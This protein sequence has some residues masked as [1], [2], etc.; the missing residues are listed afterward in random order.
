M[1]THNNSS[2]QVIKGSHMKKLIITILTTGALALPALAAAPYYIAGDFNGWNPAGNL[3]TE[4]F[5]GSGIWQVNLSSLSTGR[6]EFKVT[7]GSS[8]W[9]WSYPG[10]NSWL[11][12]DGSGN[13]TLT[14]DANTYADGWS[15]ASQRIGLSVDPGS[16]TAAGDF[17]VAAGE[18]SNWNNAAGNMTAMG[19]GIYRYQLTALGTWNWKAVVTGSWDSISSDNRSVGTAN[20]QFTVGAGEEANLYVN[21]FAGTAKIDIVTVPEPSTLALLGAGLAGLVCLRRRQ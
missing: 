8:T 7:D 1:S 21:A 12:P 3:M 16:W 13:V 10:P 14:Y 9:N 15:S 2:Y 17:Q 4:T 20:W 19:G 18:P 6:H 11:Y 5:S